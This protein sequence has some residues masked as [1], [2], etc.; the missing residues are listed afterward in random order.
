MKRHPGI[1]KM[2]ASRF[3]VRA[4]ATDPRTGREKEREKIINGSLEDAVT[5]Q[6]QMREEIRNVDRVAQQVPKLRGCAESWLKSRALGLKVSSAN[7]YADILGTHVIPPLGDIFVDKLTDS[8]VRAWQ[9]KLLET[10]APESANNCLRVLRS[11]MA[12]ATAEFGL[13][14]NPASQVRLLPRARYTDEEPGLFTAEEL[15]KVLAAFKEYK[16]KQYPLAETL[17]L[18]GVRYGEAVGLRWGDVSWNE[19]LIHIRRRVYG[20]RARSHELPVG[21]IDVPKTA[22]G[23][24]TVPMAPELAKV[25]KGHRAKLE[26]KGLPI[27]DDAWV[28]PW[29]NG[30]LL[31]QSHLRAPLRFVLAKLGIKKRVTTHGLRRS[32]NNLIRQVAGGIIVRSIVGHSDEGMTEHYSRVGG[33]EKLAAVGGIVKLIPGLNGESG[34]GDGAA[35]SPITKSN[36][37]NLL[38]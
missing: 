34:G 20:S 13:H 10:L 15:G 14:H 38:N 33:A 24:R 21:L 18:T 30:G 36:Q 6:V 1:T 19:G 12:D 11:V 4:R 22:G 8:D 26:A 29:R 9:R 16:P 5:L 27:D 7:N 31:P 35:N 28:F 32:F 17:A 2:S 23:A 3:R 37:P 25:L